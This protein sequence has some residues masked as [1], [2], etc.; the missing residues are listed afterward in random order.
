MFSQLCWITPALT[1]R[2][3]RCEFESGADDIIG[4]SQS[5]AERSGPKGMCRFGSTICYPDG[6][7]KCDILTEKFMKSSVWAIVQEA[8]SMRSFVDT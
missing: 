6:G 5:S 7:V 2:R 1:E 3:L 4:V 8:G